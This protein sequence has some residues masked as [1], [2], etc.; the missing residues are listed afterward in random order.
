LPA[1]SFRGHAEFAPQLR[2]VQLNGPLADVEH[3]CD[4][5]GCIPERGRSCRFLH[6]HKGAHTP[7]KFFEPIGDSTFEPLTALPPRPGA[8]THATDSQW[9]ENEL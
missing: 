4:A 8:T 3:L 1:A 6:R 2:E 5:L 9:I 7:R